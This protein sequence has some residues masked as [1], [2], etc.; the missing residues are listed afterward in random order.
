MKKIPVLLGFLIV[1][2]AVGLVFSLSS[3][4]TVKNRGTVKAVGISIYEDAGCTVPLTEID[5]GEVYPDSSFTYEAWLKNEGNVA[6]TVAM[7]TDNWVPD[8]A[9]LFMLLS[10]DGEGVVI[11]PSLTEYVVF[12]LTIYSNALITDF[13][14]DI[15]LVGSEV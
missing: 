10:W 11:E 2:L 6:V 3:F 13:S 4:L 5:W 1:T 15:H 12:T 9:P 7:H 8:D 14:F